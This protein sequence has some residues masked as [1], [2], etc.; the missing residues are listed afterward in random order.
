MATMPPYRSEPGPEV[1]RIQ[2]QK[3]QDNT[4]KPLDNGFSM[5]FE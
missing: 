2:H 4:V 5:S 1:E 3:G